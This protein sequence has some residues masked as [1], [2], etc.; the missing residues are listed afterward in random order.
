MRVPPVSQIVL[1]EVIVVRVM[2]VLMQGRACQVARQI[3]VLMVSSATM[4]V[5]VMSRRVRRIHVVLVWSVV[6][7]VVVYLIW[8]MC[9]RDLYQIAT[10]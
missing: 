6:M 10:V 1:T 5:S 3:H 2:H 9:L 8:V 4:R 7:L